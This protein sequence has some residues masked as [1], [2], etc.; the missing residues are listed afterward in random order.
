MVGIDQHT[1]CGGLRHRAR[2]LDAHIACAGVHLCIQSHRA[3]CAAVEQHDIAALC[4]Y[5]SHVVFRDQ[6]LIDGVNRVAVVIA[7]A[8]A[9]RAR[10]GNSARHAV[11]V[12]VQSSQCHGTR[13]ARQ[14]LNHQIARHDR[15]GLG[16]AAITASVAAHQA[17]QA[18]CRAFCTHGEAIDRASS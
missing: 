10:R 3:G 9:R 17:D 7:E 12:V 13:C 4:R 1:A 6:V 8:D 2:G 18:A 15:L 11:H 16:H 5:A 14:V